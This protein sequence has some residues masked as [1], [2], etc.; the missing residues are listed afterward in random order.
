MKYPKESIEIWDGVSQQRR[1][2]LHAIV[3][4]AKWAHRELQLIEQE[5]TNREE[6]ME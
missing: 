4:Y 6:G 2:H 5:L 1:P 3:A